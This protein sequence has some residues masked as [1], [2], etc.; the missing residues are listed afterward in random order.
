MEIYVD[1]ASAGDPGLSG[2]GI[3][4]IAEGIYEQIS[5]PLGTMSNHEAEFIAIEKALTIAFSYSPTFIRLYSDSKIA[6]DSIEKKHAKNP[7]FK[8]HLDAILALTASLELFFI[9][10]LPSASNKKADDLARQAI[11]KQRSARS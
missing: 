6:I 10:W 3:V 5:I 8:P 2:A 9:Q 4:I 7:L 11:Q 1:G